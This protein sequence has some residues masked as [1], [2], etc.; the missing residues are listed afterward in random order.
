MH[1]EPVAH[2]V[3]YRVDGPDGAVV[4]SG[5]TIVCDE[6]EALARGAEVLVHEI[7]LR[8]LTEATRSSAHLQKLAAYHADGVDLGAM[9]A[10][11]GVPRLLLTHLIPPPG[12]DY[13]EFV[14]EVRAGGFEGE[15]IV[16][17]DLTSVAF[18]TLTPRRGTPRRA[19]AART[20]A[21]R[22]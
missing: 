9:A 8:S 11:S 18:S 14:A 4:V 2:A 5:D 15:V 20:P 19:S 16:G 12:D 21:S 22:R 10:R 3:A 1:H 6:V 7:F 17:P 13:D